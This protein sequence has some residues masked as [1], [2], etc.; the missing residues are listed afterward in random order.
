MRY[1]K[2]MGNK[3]EMKKLELE[4][5]VAILLTT[6]D[7]ELVKSVLYK[8][9]MDSEDNGNENNPESLLLQKLTKKFEL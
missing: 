3:T 8:A 9:I 2:Y 6:E 5:Q 1:N 7:L 4:K